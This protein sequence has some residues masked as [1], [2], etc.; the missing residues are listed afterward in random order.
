M[1]ATADHQE[2]YDVTQE[3]HGRPGRPWNARFQIFASTSITCDYYTRRFNHVAAFGIICEWAPIEWEAS[4]RGSAFFFFQEKSEYDSRRNW[5]DQCSLMYT[6]MSAM[7]NT[8]TIYIFQLPVS[9]WVHVFSLPMTIKEIIRYYICTAC[10]SRPQR[11]LLTPFLTTLLYA[12]FCLRPV[13]LQAHPLLWHGGLTQL[14]AGLRTICNSSHVNQG[15][16]N[17][18]KSIIL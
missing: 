5:T 11:S 18:K 9:L 13:P 2:A 14:E 7:Q 4:C 1:Q 10:P 6:C 3:A 17:G 15:I 12:V 8:M 16:C